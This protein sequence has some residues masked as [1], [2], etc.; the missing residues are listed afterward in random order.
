MGTLVLKVDP[1]TPH[2]TVSGSVSRI[3]LRELDTKLGEHIL[4]CP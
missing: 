1:Y 4:Q 2:Q 3:V